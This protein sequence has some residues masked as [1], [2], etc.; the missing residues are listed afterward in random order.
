[1][2]SRRGPQSVSSRC[3]LS[4]RSDHCPLGSARY[5]AALQEKLGL[6]FIPK[7]IS[8]KSI[9]ALLVILSYLEHFQNQ[10]KKVSKLNLRILQSFFFD[11]KKVTP[12][13]FFIV[14]DSWKRRLRSL[15]ENDG[16]HVE[17]TKNIHRCVLLPKNRVE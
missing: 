2:M 9:D 10:L 15:S 6:S 13:I 4:H 12:E 1:M 7:G 3:V 17:K 8:E 14:F 16:E 5:T 11:R